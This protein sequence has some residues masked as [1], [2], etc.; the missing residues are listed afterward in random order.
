M[1]RYNGSSSFAASTS[2]VLVQTVTEVRPRRR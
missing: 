1:V 2:V